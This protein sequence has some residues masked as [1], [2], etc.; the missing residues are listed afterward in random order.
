M[1]CIYLLGCSQWSDKPCDSD[2]KHVY[3]ELADAMI[4]YI[5]IADVLGVDLDKIIQDKMERNARKYPVGLSR[6]TGGKR[7]RSGR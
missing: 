2:W 1:S 5:Q 6:T 4:Y 3:E 7:E